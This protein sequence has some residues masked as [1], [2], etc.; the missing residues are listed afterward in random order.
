MEML[1]GVVLQ[2][3]KAAGFYLA[4]IALV[5]PPEIAWLVRRQPST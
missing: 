1:G 2:A 4:L 5:R 3:S